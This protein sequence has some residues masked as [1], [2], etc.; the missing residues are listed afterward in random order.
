MTPRRNKSKIAT[1]VRIALLSSSPWLAAHAGAPLPVR[2]TS[3]VISSEQQ[4]RW[5]RNRAQLSLD[6]ATPDFCSSD[7]FALLDGRGLAVVVLPA[8]VFAQPVDFD[9]LLGILPDRFLGLTANAVSMLSGLT[10]TSSALFRFALGE[11]SRWAA[12]VGLDRCGGVSGGIGAVSRHRISEGK[13]EGTDVLCLFMLAR[14]IR[15]VIETQ[16]RVL[17]WAR[18]QVPAV[19]IGGPFEIN[20]AIPAAAQL[21][22]GGLNEGWEEPEHALDTPPRA[23]E[24]NALVRLQVDEWPTGEDELRHLLWRALDRACEAFGDRQQRFRARLGPGAG[25]MSQ[26]YA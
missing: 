14:I 13:H 8:D 6:P 18:R 12:F 23:L 15:V 16:A 20:V 21:V 17:A 1:A 4:E 3:C 25:T 26:R 5:L 22:L 24:N 7:Q 9:D 11:Q 19:D 2:Q 10:T